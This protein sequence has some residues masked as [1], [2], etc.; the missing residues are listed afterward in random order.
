MSSS[1][2]RQQL[3]DVIAHIG[4][5]CPQEDAKW[6]HKIYF[7]LEVLVHYKKAFSSEELLSAADTKITESS[8]K[9]LRAFYRVIEVISG[10]V[11]PT[12]NLYFNE[13]WKVRTV[14][15]EE[16]ST[17]HAELASVVWEMQQVFNEF[18]KNSCVVVE[19]CCS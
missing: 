18:W 19:T 15:Q 1:V 3:Q 5:K 7:R 8:C 6:W 9:I 10:P 13:L 17:D 12:A 2:T 4:F 14:L 11:C 16:S